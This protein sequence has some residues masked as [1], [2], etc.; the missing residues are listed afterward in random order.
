MK[1]LSD[2]MPNESAVI[3]DI[4]ETSALKRRFFDLGLVPDTA[5]KCVLKSVFGDPCAYLIRDSVIAIRKTD[6]KDIFVY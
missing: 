1:A 5:V 2:L 4:D 6:A 3:C